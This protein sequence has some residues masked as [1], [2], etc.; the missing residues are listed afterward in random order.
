M[1]TLTTWRE[2]DAA[3][4]LFRSNDV[5]EITATLA[6]LGVVFEQHAPVALGSDASQDEV[7]AANRSLVDA[8]VARQG[9]K[10]VDVAQLHPADT[11]EWREKAAAARSKF[12]NEHTHDDDEIRYFVDGGGAFYLHLGDHV[13]A[14]LCTAG[15][16]LNV[17]ADTTHWFDMGARPDFTAIRFFH[18]EDGWVG[19]FTGNTISSDFPDLES[20]TAASL[21]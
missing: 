7:L 17:P 13:H 12:L 8:L 16:L 20:L 4:E 1:T 10:V 9:F 15:D 21:A 14:L 2:D 11:D 3:T 18:L 6:A 19:N 5:P